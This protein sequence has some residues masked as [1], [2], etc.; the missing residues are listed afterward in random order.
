MRMEGGAEEGAGRAEREV[1]LSSDKLGMT[2]EVMATKVLPFLLPLAIENGLA[3]SQF[4]AVMA[5]VKD[6]LARV[7][8]EHRDK[9]TQ[10]NAMKDEQ[11]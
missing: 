5:L 9:L 11:Q 2:K 1:T 3:V 4:D 8:T 7:E 6:L 10:L